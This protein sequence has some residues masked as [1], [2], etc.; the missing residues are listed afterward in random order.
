ML[1]GNEERAVASACG[2]FSGLCPRFQSEAPS[3]PPGCHLGETCSYGGVYRCVTK[4]GHPTCAACAESP[5]P[6]VLAALKAEEGLDGFTT[7]RLLENPARIREVGLDATLAE[8]T[9]RRVPAEELLAGWNDGRSMISYGTACALLAPAE[10]RTVLAQVCAARGGT[11]SEE[12]SKKW[13]RAMKEA[14]RRLAEERGTSLALR[15]KE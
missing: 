14:L 10:V 6:R 5:C 8:E 13:H 1:D 2:R 11:G 7:Q 4:R 3:R 9:K 15:R 12:D